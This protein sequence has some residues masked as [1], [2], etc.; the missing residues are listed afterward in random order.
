MNGPP[1][2]RVI[3]LLEVMILAD[4]FGCNNAFEGAHRGSC[5]GVVNKKGWLLLQ[6]CHTMHSRFANT[7]IRK[8][9]KTKLHLA[10]D[11]AEGIS[12]YV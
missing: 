11:E 3:R 9:D 10:L 8:A 4:M 6:L 2:I 5:F 7:S 1:I 12:I